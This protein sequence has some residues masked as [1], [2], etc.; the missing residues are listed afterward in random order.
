MLPMIVHSNGWGIQSWTI[1]NMVIF[2]ELPPFDATIFADTGHEA[3]WTYDF[4]RRWTP[5]L[6]EHDINVVT[7]RDENVRIVTDRQGG[8][9]FIPAFTASDSKTGGQ[10]R[11]QCTDRWKIRPIRRWIQAH[12]GTWQQGKRKMRQP[13]EMWLGISLDEQ[14]RMKD[15]D[16]KYITNRWPLIEKRMTR[17]DCVTWLERHGLEVPQKSSCTFCPFHDRRTWHEIKA[18]SNGDWAEAVQV[19]AAIRAVRPPFDLFLHRSRKP[20]PLVD[21]STPEERGQYNL[22]NEECAGI[23]GV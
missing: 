9:I 15:S 8:E 16:V 22:W 10:L 1:H 13:V 6:E 18:G 2:G 17:A 7:V 12:R 3:S 21:F 4:A 14:Q 23:C 19:D 5:Y 20:L 11:R